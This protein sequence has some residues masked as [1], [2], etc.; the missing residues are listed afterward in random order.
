MG[1]RLG[2]RKGRVKVDRGRSP[3]WKSWEEGDSRDALPV[4]RWLVSAGVAKP[5]T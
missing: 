3:L 2:Q 5:C 4:G 1:R